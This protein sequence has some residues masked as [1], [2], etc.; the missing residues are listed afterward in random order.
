M[1]PL[2][3]GSRGAYSR[4]VDPLAEWEATRPTDFFDPALDRLGIEGLRVFGETVARVIE[5]AVAEL[6]AGRDRPS[7]DGEQVD[8][9]PAYEEAGR[10]VWASGIVAAGAHEQAALLYLLAHAGEGGHSCPVVCTAGLVRALRLHGSPDL[11]AHFL[12]PLLERDYGRAQRGAQFLTERQGGRCWRDPCLGGAQRLRVAA[13]RRE[14]VLRRRR[15]RFRWRSVHSNKKSA[16]PLKPAFGCRRGPP[17][18]CRCPGGPPTFA[19]PVNNLL[20]HR[21]RGGFVG[22]VVCRGL[23]CSHACARAPDARRI[24][25]ADHQRRL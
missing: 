3:H 6:E 23:F 21:L 17:Q 4:E 25:G 18:R 12:P 16:G 22:Q 1:A 20:T 19:R 7:T 5:P 24:R 2:N 14:V 10:A 11:Q 13:L 9:D 8:F 15:W